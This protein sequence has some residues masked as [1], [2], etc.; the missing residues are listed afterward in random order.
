MFT[1]E[2]YT[3]TAVIRL[4][5]SEHWLILTEAYHVEYVLINVY[6]PSTDKC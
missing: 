1:S 5:L 6:L 2:N 3:E 4:R